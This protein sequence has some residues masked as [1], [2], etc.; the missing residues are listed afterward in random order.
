[1]TSDHGKSSPIL[2]II[3][4]D[5]EK[6]YAEISD[7]TNTAERDR[8][9]ATLRRQA[10]LLDQVSDAVISTDKDFVVTSWNR[11]AERVYG[12][13]AEEVIGKRTEDVLQ[14]RFLTGAVQDAMSEFAANG[15]WE[16]EVEQRRKDGSAV[17]ILSA[18]TLLRNDAGEL[19]GTVGVNRDISKLHRSEAALRVAEQRY[20]HL[21]DRA[22]VMYLA[23]EDQDGYPIIRDVNNFYL[24]RLGYTRAEVV[25]RNAMDFMAPDSRQEALREYPQIV[26]GK[27]REGVRVLRT[28]DGEYIETLMRTTPELDGE[29]QVVG[30]L[31]MYTDLSPLK[32]SEQRLRVEA[33]RVQTLLRVASQLNRQAD[34]VSLMQT[35]CTEVCAALDVPGVSLS[36]VDK[37]K[38]LFFHGADVGLPKGYGQLTKPVAIPPHLRGDLH[39]VELIRVNPISA[40]VNSPNYAMYVEQG[41]QIGVNVMLVRDAQLIGSLNLHI[42]DP[43]RQFGSDDLA[44]LRGIADVVTQAIL[45]AQLREETLRYA[46]QLQE[47]VNE[48]TMELEEALAQAQEADRL[49]SQFVSDINHELRTPLTNIILYLG[50]LT[51]GKPEKREQAIAIMQREAQRLRQMIEDVLDL[52]RL[53]L[54]RT[55]IHARPV[56]LGE[57]VGG[58]IED[59]EPLIERSPLQLSFHAQPGLAPISIDAS[60]IGRVLTNLLDNAFN[61]TAQGHVRIEVKHRWVDSIEWQTVSVTDSGPGIDPEDL[62]NL[63]LRFYRGQSARQ[64]GAPGTG[65]GLAICQEIAELHGGHIAVETEYGKGSTFT[66]WLPVERA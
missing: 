50:L 20:R 13:L 11:G 35:I 57:L 3:P 46:S 66:L 18:V 32:Q 45:N 14:T 10:L 39:D 62:P 42:T 12:W 19:I 48:R 4:D 30:F 36:L 59:R 54:D 34:L 2:P 28:R 21:F 65:L 27:D 31:T 52:S 8:L 41:L 33:G 22:P 37:E 7:Q 43:K 40:L 58:V 24:H 29:G 53:D 61:Y 60:L 9:E 63:F 25:G 17:P 23:S 6:V 44:L 15:Y 51:N 16:G 26:R 38:G 5:G 47:L 56:R 64:S 1:M 55:E 49:K